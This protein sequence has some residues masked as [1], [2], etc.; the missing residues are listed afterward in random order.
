MAISVLFVPEKMEVATYD[1]V[2]RR[3]DAA[4]AFPAKGLISHTCSIVDGQVRVF[5]IWESEAEFREFGKTL[6]PILSDL[7]V[8]AVPQ[9]GVVHN[10]MP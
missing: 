8:A 4:S 2:M 5:D 10:R 1:E 9:I 3:L 7:G 6:L